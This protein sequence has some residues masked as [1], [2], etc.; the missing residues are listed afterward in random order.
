[1]NQVIRELALE[2]GFISAGFSGS[3]VVLQNEREILKF[4]NLIIEECRGIALISDSN[5][6]TIAKEINEHFMRN[7][8]E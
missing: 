2:A 4:A 8:A 1:M 7:T 6:E 5:G 3:K